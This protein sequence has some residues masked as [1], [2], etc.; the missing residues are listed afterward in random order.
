MN[1][2]LTQE[3][4]LPGKQTCHA[5]CLCSFTQ[6]AGSFVA[7]RPH[8]VKPQHQHE[9]LSLPQVLDALAMMT[10]VWPLSQF[11]VTRMQRGLPAMGAILCPAESTRV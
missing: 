4:L 5:Q 11:S 6:P 7:R 2:T 3:L 10:L 8:N 9:T 1:S